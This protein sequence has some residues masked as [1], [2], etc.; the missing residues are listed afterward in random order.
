LEQ[1]SADLCRCA[2]CHRTVHNI[3]FT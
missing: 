3:D 2:G 1:I